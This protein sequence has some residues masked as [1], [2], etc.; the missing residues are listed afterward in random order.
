MQ[1]NVKFDE[2]FSWHIASYLWRVEV[3]SQISVFKFNILVSV[4]FY[5]DINQKYMGP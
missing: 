1:Q 5:S 2:T 3:Y 4:Y